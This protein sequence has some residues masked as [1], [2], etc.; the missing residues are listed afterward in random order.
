[1]NLNKLKQAEASFLLRYP[2]GFADPAMQAVR[3]KHNVDRIVAY[4][5]ESLTRAN[6]GRPQFVADTLLNIISRSSMVS[7]FEKP[8]FRAF[9]DALGSDEKE[10]LAYAV[11]Q[12]LHGRKQAGFETMLGMLQHHRIAKWAVISAV[13]FY[14][15][16][17]REVFVKPT[18]AKNIIRFLEVSDL[19]YH[20]T[21][22]WAFYKGYRDLVA[23]VKKAVPRTLAPNNAALTGF[24]MMSV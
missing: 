16:P 17:T 8:P 18:T 11:E 15:A 1:M 12:R 14:Y 9:V 2:E 23:Q 13:P 21:P 19:Q 24:L 10:A 22:S 6:C 4:A 3:K 20:A 5:Q 7:R